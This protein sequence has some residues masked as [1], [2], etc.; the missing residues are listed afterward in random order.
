[1]IPRAKG[2]TLD[3]KVEVHPAIQ[4][5]ARAFKMRTGLILREKT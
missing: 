3:F 2:D 4:A 1:M 5:Q